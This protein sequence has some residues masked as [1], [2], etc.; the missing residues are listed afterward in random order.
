MIQKSTKERQKQEEATIAALTEE[1][2]EIQARINADHE[3]AEENKSVEPES[4]EKKEKRIKR[5]VDSAPK[6]KYSK[7]Q[8]MTQE[9][10]S[11]KSD[12]EE[13][14]DYEQENEELRMWLTVVSNEKETSVGI[15][16][17]MIQ[18]STKE[19]QK[20]K[21]ATIAALTE[22]FDEIQARMNADHE[23]A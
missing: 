13:S 10:E 6:Q 7:K 23:L 5:V 4:K 18:K 21:E 12:E 2:D 15:L 8:K 9:Q 11:A 19:R 3:L 16:D 14:T 17:L 20:Q 1:F 22:E